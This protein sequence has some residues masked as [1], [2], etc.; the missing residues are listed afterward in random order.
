MRQTLGWRS[1]NTTV[2]PDAPAQ[3]RRPRAFP[4]KAIRIISLA[5]DLSDNPADLGDKEEEDQTDDGLENGATRD[6]DTLRAGI[7][8]L[9]S[10]LGEGS[11]DED[12][13]DASEGPLDEID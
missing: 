2:P 8:Q 6:R 3:L 4:T 5:P 11:D 13:L 7:L 12:N 9:V 10:L 1:T